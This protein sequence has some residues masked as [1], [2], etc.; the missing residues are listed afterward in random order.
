VIEPERIPMVMHRVEPT[1][2]LPLASC[3]GGTIEFMCSENDWYWKIEADSFY[4]LWPNVLNGMS[5]HIQ[6]HQ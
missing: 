4:E 2:F 3:D 5:E 1:I 6:Q